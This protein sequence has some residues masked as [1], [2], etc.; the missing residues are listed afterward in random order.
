MESPHTR[1]IALKPCDASRGLVLADAGILPRQ[2]R[3]SLIKAEANTSVGSGPPLRKSSTD[4][5]VESSKTLGFSPFFHP[6]SPPPH[7]SISQQR[8]SAAWPKPFQINALNLFG[9]IT[10]PSGFGEK[11]PDRRENAGI[12]CL[13]VTAVWPPPCAWAC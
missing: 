7:Q 13:S 6:Q 11:S 3:Q 12:F 5:K 8:R 1:L 4:L 10:L 9:K 2:I